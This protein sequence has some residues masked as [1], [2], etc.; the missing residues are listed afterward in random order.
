[1]ATLISTPTDLYNL[2]IGVSSLSANYELTNNIDMSFTGPAK[3]IGNTDAING[4]TGTFDGKGYT[5]NIVLIDSQYCGF[6]SILNNNTATSIKDINIIY[7]IPVTLNPIVGGSGGVGGF[8]GS[9]IKADITGC[10]VT[11]ADG[12]TIGNNTSDCINVGG[13][14]GQGIN[15]DNTASP[16]FTAGAISNSSIVANNNF[17]ITGNNVLNAGFFAGIYMGILSNCTG[18]IGN[19]SSISINNTSG[20]CESVGAF[21]GTLYKS[22]NNELNI[23]NNCTITTKNVVFNGVGGFVGSIFHQGINEILVDN[24]YVI[25]GS[26]TTIN[27]EQTSVGGVFGSLTNLGQLYVWNGG[28]T[29]PSCNVTLQNSIVIFNNI[30]DIQSDIVGGTIGANPIK[31]NNTLNNITDMYKTYKINGITVGPIWGINSPLDIYTNVLSYSCGGPIQGSSLTTISELLTTYNTIFS[32][33]SDPFFTYIRSVIIARNYECTA[34]AP[35][36]TPSPTPIPI[37]TPC[38]TLKK[39]RFCYSYKRPTLTNECCPEK[40]I[41]PVNVDLALSISTVVNNSTRASENMLLLQQQQ[42]FAQNVYSTNVTNMVQSTIA[43]ANTIQST[44]Q[45]QLAE[46]RQMRYE[47]Y[48]PYIP[49]VIPQHVMDLQMRTANV[50]VPMSFTTMASC[51]GNQFVTK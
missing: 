11:F 26:N 25:Y 41:T 39:C 46:L 12:C 23:G 43:N 40:N 45:G 42:L 1:M 21:G 17:T 13:F 47:P 6:F 7:N 50:G 29:I 19:N 36:P 35:A 33:I 14:V 34:P 10:N 20:D 30:T 27:C 49:P 9:I 38:P 8:V 44:I 48:R 4:F 3:S 24:N 32:L 15:F 2:M 31:V 18:T 37:Y 22:I 51:K 16:K 5:V 28:F